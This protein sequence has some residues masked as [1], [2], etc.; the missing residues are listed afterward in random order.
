MKDIKNFFFN[1]EI[2]LE[3]LNNGIK[4]KI[5]SF[6]DNL[7]VVEVQFEEGAIGTLHAHHHEQSTYIIS[8]EYE[9]TINGVTKLV[10]VG[11]TMYFEPNVL[12]GALCT[13]SGTL[14]DI[15]TPMRE[16]FIK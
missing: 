16:D 15:F 11:D 10:K 3:D 7:M 6:N 8:G 12:H 4:R 14:L 13:K 5:L 1:S 9:F 2:E